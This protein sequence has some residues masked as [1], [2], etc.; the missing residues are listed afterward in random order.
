MRAVT[1]TD[2]EEGRRAAMRFSGLTITDST[3]DWLDISLLVNLL[4]SC[5]FLLLHCITKFYFSCYT[6]I[7]FLFIYLSH[8]DLIVVSSSWTMSLFWWWLLSLLINAIFILFLIYLIIFYFNMGW[9]YI[10]MYYQS[11]GLSVMIGRVQ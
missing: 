5:K 11:A 2:K 4:I 10:L 8:G 7:F 9:N 1:S 3:L 6:F